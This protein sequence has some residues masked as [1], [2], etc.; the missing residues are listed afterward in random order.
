MHF[1]VWQWCFL[2][3]TAVEI[4]TDY[5]LPYIRILKYKFLGTVLRKRRLQTGLRSRSCRAESQSSSDILA[6]IK[7][8]GNC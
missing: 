8:C 3:V 2:T 7:V 6:T 4:P 5:Y 1:V